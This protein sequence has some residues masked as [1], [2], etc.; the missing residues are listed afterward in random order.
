ETG[1]EFCWV[2]RCASEGPFTLH[3]EEI[4]RGNWFAPEFVTR[5]MAEQPLEFASAFRL[6]WEKLRR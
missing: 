4:E 5:W 6:I 3:P 2:Y 1:W